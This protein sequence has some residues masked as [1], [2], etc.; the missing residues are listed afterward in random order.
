MA[1]GLYE[2]VKLEVSGG[3]G[4]EV[5]LRSEVRLSCP[6]GSIMTRV[7]CDG[8]GMIDNSIRAVN[9]IIGEN[10]PRLGSFFAWMKAAETNKGSAAP[11][12]C[13]LTLNHR[14][15]RV[16]GESR[17]NDVVVASVKAYI[18]GLNKL[19]TKQSVREAVSV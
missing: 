5:R 13:G 10:T 4:S 8:V 2:L 3:Y 14:G 1:N 17:D 12:V 19:L 6:D 16:K 9:L 18:D 7:C 11:G 15:E